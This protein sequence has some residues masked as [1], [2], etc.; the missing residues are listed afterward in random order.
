MFQVCLR[1]CPRGLRL[2]QE[3]DARNDVR[4]RRGLLRGRRETHRDQRHCGK[5][6]LHQLLALSGEHHGCFMCPATL[7][8]RRTRAVLQVR[9]S[10]HCL[11]VRQ[12][13]TQGKYLSAAPGSWHYPQTL[14]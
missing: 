4:L 2:S 6:P 5:L 13:P 10:Q 11:Q 1:K 14:D 8:L 3:T 12:E 9:V 7:P